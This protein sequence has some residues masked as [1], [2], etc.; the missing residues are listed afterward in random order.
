MIKY[1]KTERERFLLR[2]KKNRET[3]K[4]AAKSHQNFVMNMIKGLSHAVYVI[5]F[6]MSS[7][8]WK[9]L[10]KNV[11][12]VKHSTQFVASLSHLEGCLN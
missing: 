8:M 5:T 4:R 11:S 6:G 1:I 2:E 3:V 10:I 9:V 12:T 7:S